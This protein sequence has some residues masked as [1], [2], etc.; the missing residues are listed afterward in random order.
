MRVVRGAAELEQAPAAAPPRGAGRVRRRP[1]ARRAL[2][3]APA[4]HRGPGARRPPRRVRAPRRARV[5]A[6]APPPE[7]R[8]G[9]AVARPSTDELRARMGE[10]AVALARACGYEGAGTVEF[11]APAGGGEFFFLEMNTRLQVEHPV[12][13][14]VYGVDLVEQ[15]LRVAAGEPLALRQEDLVPRGHAVEARLYAEDPAAGF[16]PVDRHGARLRR[17]DRRARRLR[18]ARPAARSATAY[19]PML[20]KVIAHGPDRAT[21]LDRLDRALATYAIARRDDERRVHARAARARRRPRRRA[22]H[23]PARAGPAELATPAPDDLLAGRR[24]RRRRRAPTPPGPWR[25]RARRPRR[26]ARA[27][28]D[29]HGRRAGV[30]R[31][32]DPS[33]RRPRRT[34]RSTASPGATPSRST[35]TMPS[36]C[37]RRPPRSRSARSA[38][39]APAP[40]RC[41]AR[42]RRRCRARSCSSTSPTAT[43]STRATCCSCSSR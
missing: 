33:R 20:A 19:D 35:A 36:W 12:T 41:A 15:Q 34:S 23:R 7:G 38:S 9:G 17:A 37:P 28:R 13:E 29:G 5:L 32:G 10:A 26:G 8:R 2:P 3:R 14:L 27:R 25:R 6:P 21:A 31:R 11:I 39:R 16:L 30:E 18:R 22:G 42:W 4:P 1:R 24:A 43:R 40:R